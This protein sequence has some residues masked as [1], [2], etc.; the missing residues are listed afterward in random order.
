MVPAQ[1]GWCFLTGWSF[2][3]L[4]GVMWIKGSVDN[5]FRTYCSNIVKQLCSSF[6]RTFRTFNMLMCIINLQGGIYTYPFFQEHLIPYCL[7]VQGT[8]NV[9]HSHW[10]AEGRTP[11]NVQCW[12]GQCLPFLSRLQAFGRD[13]LKLPLPNT[14]AQQEGKAEG[15]CCAWVTSTALSPSPHVYQ[16][17]LGLLRVIWG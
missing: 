7:E 11:Q 15:L 9:T 16:E 8:G 5:K 12:S 1:L 17:L 4:K 2:K 13:S 6:C 3:I 10:M 14:G